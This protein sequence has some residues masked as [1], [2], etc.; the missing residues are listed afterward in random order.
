VPLADVISSGDSAANG[1][2][3]ESTF[4][5]R[6]PSSAIAIPSELTSFVLPQRNMADS[7]TA[8]ARTHTNATLAGKPIMIAQDSI[9]TKLTYVRFSLIRP[10][11]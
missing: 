4:H 5:K 8:L 7:T 10:T 2:D 6:R 3:A 9:G 11:Y 1:R